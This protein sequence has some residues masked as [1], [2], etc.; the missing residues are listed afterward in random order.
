MPKIEKEAAIFTIKVFL[1]DIAQIYDK[2]LVKLYRYCGTQIYLEFI[3]F[4]RE[5]ASFLSLKHTFGPQSFPQKY[6]ALT[7]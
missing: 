5:S 1:N 4:F 6:H 2:K 3:R 7:F